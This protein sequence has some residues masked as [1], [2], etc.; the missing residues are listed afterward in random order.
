MNGARPGPAT[1]IW[2]RNAGTRYVLLLALLVAG[3]GTQPAGQPAPQVSRASFAEAWTQR[4]VLLVGLGDSIT[5]GFGAR[6][7]HGYFD[8][9]VQNPAGDPADVQGINLRSVLPNLEARN[10]AVSGSTSL[11][12]L[13]RQLPKLETQASSVFGWVVI[14]TGGNDLIH[15][16][17]R[18]PAV[19]GAMYGA[20]WEQAQPWIA[21][22]EQRLTAILSGVRERFPGGCHVFIANIYDPTD[23]TGKIKTREVKLPDWPDGLRILTAYNAVIARVAAKWDNVHLVDIHRAFRGHGIYAGEADRWYYMNVED[24]NE[25]GYDALRRLFLAEMAKV[26]L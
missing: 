1:G 17:G 16:Y 13:N 10:L 9:L 22:F 14:T 11:D 15:S 18:N 24:P 3:C 4:Q 12:L 26:K 25:R 19:E 23:G 5:A 21:S 2:S 20:T 7:G 8:R 6:R